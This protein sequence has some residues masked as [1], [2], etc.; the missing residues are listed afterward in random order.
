MKKN[1]ARL[2]IGLMII[3]LISVVTI[4]GCQYYQKQQIQTTIVDNKGK[5]VAPLEKKT[6][7]LGH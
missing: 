2:A 3:V 1:S 4:V 6:H 5:T 7:K